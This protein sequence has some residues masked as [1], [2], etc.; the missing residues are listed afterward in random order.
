[1]ST[2]ILLFLP[3]LFLQIL[4]ANA[5]QE[6]KFIREGV[7][8]FN[9][10][11]YSNAELAF[12]K[13]LGKDSASVPAIYDLAA[14]LYKQER[15][16]E[17]GKLLDAL[18]STTQDTAVLADVWYNTGNNLL[19]EQKYD[20]AIEAYKNSLRIRPGDMDTKY[21][22]AYARKKL[23]EQQQKQQEQK[24]D[25]DQQQEQKQDK[26]EQNQDK[27]QKNENK[28][29]ELSREDMERIL[30]ALQQNEKHTK[31]KFDREKA[32][33]AKTKMEKDW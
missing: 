33:A 15:Y 7:R 27:S 11:A 28:S 32:R 25:Q 5:Q 8:E 31:E 23:K 12:R 16:E 21:N 4:V 20:G 14:S 2:R 30:K 22:L 10:E 19:S 18:T 17:A 6:R 24:Q 1:M 9:R 26:S 13:A 29:Q 3:F